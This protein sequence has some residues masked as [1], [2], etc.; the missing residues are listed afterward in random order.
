VDRKPERAVQAK[1]RDFQRKNKK[2]MTAE[3]YQWKNTLRRFT[4]VDFF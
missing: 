1:V 2:C 4:N 3:A